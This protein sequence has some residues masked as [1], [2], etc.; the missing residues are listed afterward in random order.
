M[1][2]APA[3]AKRNTI[4]KTSGTVFAIVLIVAGLGYRPVTHHLRA[5]AVLTR[6]G[7]PEAQGF[8][9][10]YETNEVT[11]EDF[12]FDAN[13]TAVRSRMYVPVGAKEPPPIV[14]LHGVHHLG[15][16]EPR[17]KNFSRAMA[18]HGYLVLTPE[19]PGIDNY[20]VTGASVP[21]IGAAA[22]ELSRRSGAPKVGVLGLSFAGGLALIAAS[23]PRYADN[24]AWV[25]AVGAQDDVARVLKFFATNE[26]PLPT[27][28]TEKLKAHEYG[29]LVVVYSH[30]EEF[31]SA[32]DAP[33]AERAL[34]HLLWEDMAVAHAEATQMSPDGQRRMQ[35][36]FEHHTESLA[37]VLLASIDKY[38]AEYVPASP[39]GNISGLH[40][41]VFL[42][43]GAADD[44]IP[45]AES[46]W[47]EHDIPAG[48]VRERLISPVV[49]H[50][51]LGQHPSARDQF[52]L[53][54]WMSA[55][56]EEADR[57]RS[58]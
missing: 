3:P 39:R 17:L 16:E 11:T 42:L 30:P 29:P 4:R 43:H 10:D 9:A 18:S 8:I 40:V 38:K 15:I 14:I 5:A 56:L 25:T 48:L 23:D 20:H 19:L 31:F 22:Q 58:R 24:I 44:V 41:P 1:P 6:I 27:G 7:Q 49:S 36:L 54:H 34:Q 51:E 2:V 53:V 26:I 35:L 52:D 28:E 47:L 21:V 50:V 45:P 46:L 37:P 57:H 32:E 13:G 33:I 12:S 55:M